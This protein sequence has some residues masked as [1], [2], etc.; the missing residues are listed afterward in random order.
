MC[1]RLTEWQHMVMEEQN[2]EMLSAHWANR[3]CGRNDV[4]KLVPVR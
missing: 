1:R 2:L 3:P 4:S